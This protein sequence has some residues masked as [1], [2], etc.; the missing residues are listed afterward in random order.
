VSKKEG[1]FTQLATEALQQ[2]STRL[3]ILVESVIDGSVLGSR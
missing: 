1:N 3:L 2:S